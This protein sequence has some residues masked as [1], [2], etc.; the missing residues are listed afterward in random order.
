MGVPVGMAMGKSVRYWPGLAC[1]VLCCAVL[2]SLAGWLG[3]ALPC[4][5]SAELGL[6]ELGWS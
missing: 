1:V 4:F 3:L 5:A 6:A 2:S